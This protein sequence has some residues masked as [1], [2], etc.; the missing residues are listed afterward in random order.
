M[1][2]L[3][4]VTLVAV[5][6]VAPELMALAIEDSRREV[7]FDHAV[8][9]SDCANAPDGTRVIY[10]SPRNMVDATMEYWT[11]VKRIVHTSHFLVIQWD[12]WIIRPDCWCDEFLQYDYIGAPWRYRDG[13]NVGNGGFSLRSMNLVDAVLDEPEI[14]NEIKNG[15]H[16]EDEIIGRQYRRLLE[17]AYGIRFAPEGVAF[18]F[19]RERNGW[20]RPEA[21]FGF[22]GIFNWHRVLDTTGLMKRS[23]L[24]NDYVRSRP[25]YKE[26]VN[27]YY[28]LGGRYFG[29]LL[30]SPRRLPSNRR[31]FRGLHLWLRGC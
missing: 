5:D 11:G 21:S 1:I 26:F 22:H 16:N 17:A 25:E 23:L 20:D 14:I 7:S 2:S 15:I 10:S 3:P 18:R 27:G 6:N 28:Q 8:L 19:S 13:R 31:F 24:I 12:S 9:F 4:D 30:L 29:R